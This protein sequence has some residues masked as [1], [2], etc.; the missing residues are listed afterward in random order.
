MKRFSFFIAL[1][2]VFLTITMCA[3]HYNVEEPVFSDKEEDEEQNEGPA[4]DDMPICEDSEKYIE[5]LIQ[6]QEEYV[7]IFKMPVLTEE[8]ILLEQINRVNEV[9]Q[10]GM[11]ERRAEYIAGILHDICPEYALDI[12]ILGVPESYNW[13]RNEYLGDYRIEYTGEECDQRG[14]ER[15]YD[16]EYCY[17]RDVCDPNVEENCVPTS[18]GPLQ[19]RHIYRPHDCDYYNNERNSIRYACQWM[20]DHYPNIAAYNA[21][22]NG[23]ARDSRSDSYGYRHFVIREIALGH[24]DIE[25]WSWGTR[26]RII[27]TE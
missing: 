21:G 12:Y 24:S 14:V 6:E 3:S 22:I 20:S 8:E 26:N 7:C 9:T 19:I 27:Y 16:S 15:V 2:L 18:C 1:S 5:F 13:N 17:G 25:N 23:A 4:I 10:R 11:S